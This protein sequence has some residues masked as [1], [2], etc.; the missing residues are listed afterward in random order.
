MGIS[1]GAGSVGGGSGP[2]G[3]NGVAVQSYSTANLLKQVEQLLVM[4][5][6]EKWSSQKTEKLSGFDQVG[7]CR[8]LAQ[9]KSFGA[10]AAYIY[11]SCFES[12]R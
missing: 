11:C 8:L 5:T 1:N 2:S 6:R 12:L 10:L 9:M 7:W 3:Q 4:E